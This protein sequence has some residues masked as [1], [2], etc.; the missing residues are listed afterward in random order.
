MIVE[1]AYP[2]VIGGVSGWLQ[3]LLN[4]L[5]DLTIHIVAI[6]ANE[7]PLEWKI[8]PPANVISV[9]E[10]A[11]EA[12]R[13]PPIRIAGGDVDS[14]MQHAIDFIVKGD[15][16]DFTLLLERLSMLAPGITPG[17]LLSHPNAFAKVRRQYEELFPYSSFHHFFWASQAL[18]GGL[19]A[20]CRAPL[21]RAKVYHSISTGFAGLLGAR[22]AHQTGRPLCLTE[23][24]IYLLERQIEIL[25]AEWIGDQVE[26]GLVLDPDLIDLREFWRRAFAHY[27]RSCYLNCTEIIALYRANS[28]VQQRLGAP[29]GRLKVVPNGIDAAR[30]ENM[31]SMRAADRPL[32]ALLGRVVPIKDV[33][34]FIKAAAIAHEKH[35]DLRFV[36]LG[37]TDEDEE[38]AKECFALC[39]SLRLTGHLE[40]AGRVRIEDWMPRIDLLVL[41]SLSE[42]QP[43]VI[44]EGG[45]CGIPVV[46]P[47]VGSC[48][49]MIEGPSGAEGECGGLVT[50]LVNPDATAEAIMRILKTPGLR[51]RMGEALRRR[52]IR[53]YD[54]GTIMRTYRDL[55]RRLAA[56]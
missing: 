25:M 15:H 12:Q 5:P 20:V 34:T 47:D 38:Y 11:L 26:R 55:Y 31:V 10:I 52:V 30:F 49:E 39:D 23:H 4:H 18:L 9:S 33:K 3:D 54:H 2:Y 53:D 14:V 16:N 42:A 1:G 8:M 56:L 41:T 21:P 28:L 13:V 43:L 50:P 35:P 6:K 27:A 22:A 48:R 36:V 29:A 45:A 37:P 44:L 19:L 51:D 24:G 7:Q 32:V 46:A 17:A 40:F